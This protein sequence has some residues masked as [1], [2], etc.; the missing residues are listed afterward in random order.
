MLRKNL[1]MAM[2]IGALCAGVSSAVTVE[3][4]VQLQVGDKVKESTIKIDSEKYTDLSMENES[5]GFALKLSDA[6]VGQERFETLPTRN[7]QPIARGFYTGKQFSL[8]AG[9]NLNGH[10]IDKTLII[11]YLSV[12]HL[13]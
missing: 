1:Y 10:K 13:P 7:G 3:A 8:D 4:L 6:K 12:K 5:L 2:L 11:K 9:C